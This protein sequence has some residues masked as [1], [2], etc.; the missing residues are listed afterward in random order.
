M[1]LAEDLGPLLTSLCPVSTT[2]ETSVYGSH[3]ISLNLKI[4]HN[5]SHPTS[6][7]IMLQKSSEVIWE[8]FIEDVT[9]DVSYKIQTSVRTSTLA[10][11]MCSLDFSVCAGYL[12]SPSWYIHLMIDI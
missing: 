10:N 3:F 1:V 6:L 8:V 7:K 4:E 12:A 11:E 5:N 9:L 2:H